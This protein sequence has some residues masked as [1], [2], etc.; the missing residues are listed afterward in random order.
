MDMDWSICPQ[1]G[2]ESS[3]GGGCY[4]WDWDGPGSAGRVPAAE[5]PVGEPRPDEAC[6]E[7]EDREDGPDV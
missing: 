5:S 7:W 3:P 6:P 4:C 2:Y 1:C